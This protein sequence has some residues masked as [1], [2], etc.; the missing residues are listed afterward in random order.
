VVVTRLDHDSNV[1]PWVQA[2]ESTGAAVR[3][4]DVDVA[5]GELPVEQFHDLIGDRTRLVA[6]TAASNAIGTVP[7][8]R[9]IADI[10]HASGALTYVDG[11]HATAHLP[12]DVRE[13][14]ADFFVTSAYKWSGPHYAALIADP[15]L[16][17]RLAPVKLLPSPTQVPDRFEYGTLSFEL[18]AGMTAAVDHLAGLAQSDAP[19]RRT[20]ILASLSAVAAY[21]KGLAAKLTAGLRSHA[22]V[23]VL[24]AAAGCPTI[25]FRIAGQA[26]AETASRLGEQ[27]ICVSSGDYYAAEYFIA[28]GLRDSGGAVRASIYHYNTAEEVDRLLAA[29]AKLI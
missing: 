26:P 19:D 7:A 13:L 2:A 29:V 1:R 28:A 23:S 10:A 4:A 24:A 16:L 20:R 25:S 14:G 5:T 15:A 22:A 8:V 12:T 18:L 27:G 17:E 3:F 11:V 21:E 9:A 6:V